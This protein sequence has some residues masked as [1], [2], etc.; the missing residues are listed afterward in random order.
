[1]MGILNV[2]RAQDATRYR[3]RRG[4]H[5]PLAV[6]RAEEKNDAGH[7]EV[8]ALIA[9]DTLGWNRFTS[10]PVAACRVPGTHLTLVREPHVDVLASQLRPRLP[11]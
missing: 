10:G 4:Y 1:V 7:P 2:A 5:V 11:Q 6:F 9:D 3:P 8:G